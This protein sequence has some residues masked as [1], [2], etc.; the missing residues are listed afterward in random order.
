MNKFFFFVFIT[1]FVFSQNRDGYQMMITHENDSFV[2]FL[3]LPNDDDNYTGGIKA[4]LFAPEFK[5][6][7]PFIPLKNAQ[8]IRSTLAVSIVAFTPNVLNSSTIQ[9]GGRPY[10]SFSAIS[11]GKEYYSDRSFLKSELYLGFFGLDFAKNAQTYIHKKGVLGTIRPVPEGWHNQ[12]GNKNIFTF[13]YAVNYL[14]K[15]KIFKTN[16]IAPFLRLDTNIGSYITD[17]SVGLNLA[18][19]LNTSPFLSGQIEHLL[20]TGNMKK[21]RFNT[22]VEPR[23]RHVLY[24]SSLEG[25]LFGDSSVY[26]IPHSDVRR[27]Q[28]E[29]N[30]GM[31]F[32][33]WDVFYLGAVVSG[34]S[35]EFK[36]GKRIYY[37]G[38]IN[39]GV[40]WE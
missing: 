4:E 20:E 35:Q 6:W 10:A 29:L 38:G 12:I 27:Y 26:K 32:S 30:T 21:F 36:G 34:R 17:V 14:K 5:F 40:R 1:N 24:N 16:N 22:Y 15:I 19:N 39:F 18:Y 23:L 7:Q 11:I 37:W 2:Y 9:Y 3:N 28:F 31:N 13:N 8:K 33:F 25:A